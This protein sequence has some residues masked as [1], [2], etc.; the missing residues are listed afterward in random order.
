MRLRRLLRSGFLGGLLGSS[1][2]SSSTSFSGSL[3]GSGTGLGLSL[4]TGSLLGSKPL[5]LSAGSSL[6]LDLGKHLCVPLAEGAQ[7]R[8]HVGAGVGN[9]LR[10]L[11]ANSRAKA[12]GLIFFKLGKSGASTAGL[13]VH[14]GNVPL[15]RIKEAQHHIH[16]SVFYLLWNLAPDTRAV[17]VGLG[18]L[19][20]SQARCGTN[21]SLVLR[22]TALR[23]PVLDQS[24]N[25]ARL[26]GA[27]AI[28]A[29][30]HVKPAR[31][32]STANRSS[33]RDRLN[34]D[35]RRV[36]GRGGLLLLR[37]SRGRSDD[38][39]GGDRIESLLSPIALLL[40]E[41]AI[42]QRGSQSS[43]VES[44]IDQTEAD[45][46][47]GKLLKRRGLVVLDSE[48]RTT[49]LA[50]PLLQHFTEHSVPLGR[51]ANGIEEVIAL[52]HARVLLGHATR[53]RLLETRGPV[54]RLAKTSLT[55]TSTEHVG[56]EPAGPLAQHLDELVSE[57][58]VGGR[59]ERVALLCLGVVGAT[60]GLLQVESWS[61]PLSGPRDDACRARR[62][63]LGR[64]TGHTTHDAATDAVSSPVCSLTGCRVGSLLAQR[65]DA[66][67]SS[68]D[69]SLLAGR[70]NAS[71]QSKF[72]SEAW[73]FTKNTPNSIRNSLKSAST[74]GF[75]GS[76]LLFGLVLTQP[77]HLLI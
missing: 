54:D 6:S 46:L 58:L 56:E 39:G 38:L 47:S 44:S 57:S 34:I 61:H 60:R 29:Q 30:P 72:A 36:A 16:A 62:D 4:L 19:K 48:S 5:G 20:F 43:G 74:L 28:L 42:G 52:E 50:C 37:G 59:H 73:G 71:G 12:V 3:L 35:C 33:S 68:L 27:N 26:I 32:F 22:S 45:C 76:P 65:L 51:V 18:F 11:A 63:S 10:H 7:L 2:L 66:S 9:A 24:I 31:R 23:D 49:N 77:L 41:P 67:G 55:R 53:H 40:G 17:P 15:P 13:P 70:G 75:C 14:V 1:S 21:A 8:H 69:R 25:R 64:S